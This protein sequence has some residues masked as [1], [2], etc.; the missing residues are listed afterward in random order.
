MTMT[1]QTAHA[2]ADA[3]IQNI[4]TLRNVLRLAK[5]EDVFGEEDI[6]KTEQAL[7]DILI[8][9]V[10]RPIVKTDSRDR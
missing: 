5:T 8:A 1:D 9:C 6:T 10:S 2:I 7:T 4:T 3:V